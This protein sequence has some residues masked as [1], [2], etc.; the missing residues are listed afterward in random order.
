[1]A[2][3]L[4]RAVSR[5]LDLCPRVVAVHDLTTKVRIELEGDYYLDLYHN[6]TLG[7]YAYTLIHQDQRLC[8]WDNAPH[9]PDV[10]GYPHHFHRQDGSIEPSAF[11]G[12]PEQDIL[13]VAAT[14]NSFLPR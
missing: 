12:D 3:Q 4:A 2:R 8:G 5:F 10:A 14:V 7:K 11:T 9:H 1:M 13:A 6:A